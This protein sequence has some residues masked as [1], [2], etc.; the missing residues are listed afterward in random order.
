MDHIV[1]MPTQM[2]IHLRSQRRALG[3]TQAMVG[4]QIGL[5]QKRLSTLERH[6]DR[7]SVK[8][9]LSLAAVLKL[10]VVLRKKSPAITL[11]PG[12]W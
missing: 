12:E 1:L 9:L 7:I 2:G 11:A 4:S 6:P 10:E 5:S 3:L 8:Q